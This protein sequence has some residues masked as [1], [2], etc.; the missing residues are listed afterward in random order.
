MATPR[1]LTLQQQPLVERLEGRRLLANA[2]LLGPVTLTDN[3]T[4][5]TATG[6]FAGLGNQDL[7]VTLAATG[8]ATVLCHNPKG[9]VAPGQTQPVSV[10]GSQTDIEVKNGRARFDVTTPAPA[11]TGNPCPNGKWTPELTNVTFTSATLTAEQGGVTVF[12]Q[13]FD[14][15]GAAS[16][17]AAGALGAIDWTWSPDSSGS[18]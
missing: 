12:T 4:T 18:D 6:T 2:H 9:N 11:I 15:T 13:T 7:T 3:G 5:L 1:A 8:S 14:L 10:S 16:A 17:T